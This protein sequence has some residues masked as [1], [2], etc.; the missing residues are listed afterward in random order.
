MIG[1]EFIDVD[2]SEN[3]FTQ[4]VSNDWKGSCMVGVGVFVKRFI[5]EVSR[6]LEDG[7]RSV[8]S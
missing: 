2:E 4:A 8:I 3:V 5:T 6:K 7:T 1:F